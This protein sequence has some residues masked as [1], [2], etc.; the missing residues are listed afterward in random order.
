MHTDR[1]CK[2]TLER[3]VG[4]CRNKKWTNRLFPCVNKNKN[5]VSGLAATGEVVMEHT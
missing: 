2:Y 1:I 4:Q 5:G 3:V